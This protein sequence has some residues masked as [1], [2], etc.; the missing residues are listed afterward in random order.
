MHIDHPASGD[1]SARIRIV[2][3]LPFGG[4]LFE[5]TFQSVGGTFIHGWQT[6]TINITRAA[7]TYTFTVTVNLT[8]D[9]PEIQFVQSRLLSVQEFKR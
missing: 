5:E 7:G 2:Q 4:Q 8:A 3:A 9:N 6:P 1:I